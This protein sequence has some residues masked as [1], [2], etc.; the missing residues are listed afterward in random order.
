M[1][2]KEKEW[3]ENLCRQCFNN[4]NVILRKSML[5]SEKVVDNKN[6]GE[7]CNNHKINSSFRSSESDTFQSTAG[8]AAKIRLHST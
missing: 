5:I 2:T 3:T 4:H 8:L 1:L 7:L 6:N